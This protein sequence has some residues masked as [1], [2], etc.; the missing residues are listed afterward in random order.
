MANEICLRYPTAAPLANPQFAIFAG[1]TL[2]WN[3]TTGAL[4]AQSDPTAWTAA[5]FMGLTPLYT[6]GSV[7]VGD[8]VGTMPTGIDQSQNYTI[9]FYNS[10]GTPTPLSELPVTQTWIPG[11][12]GPGG[13]LTVPL[14][15]DVPATLSLFRGDDY[16]TTTQQEA[17]FSSIHWPILTGT[18]LQILLNI[19][20]ASTSR[21]QSVA[22]STL[23]SQAL[24]LN[25]AA[26]SVSTVNGVTTQTLTF[27]LSAEQTNNLLIDENGT[28]QIYEVV[29]TFYDGSVRTLT[30]GP[31]AVTG[32]VRW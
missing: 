1:L 32:T 27:P 5:C 10:V 22:Y 2:M 18:V 8:Y 20:K 17:V 7:F 29:A 11:S 19:R 23:V 31:V 12:G 26:L 30:T 28:L 16:N 25:S 13:W 21:F 24:Q 14:S 3:N 4:V 15:A 9:R 6:A